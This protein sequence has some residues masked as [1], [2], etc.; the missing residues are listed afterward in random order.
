MTEHTA[1]WPEGVVARYVTVA[2]ALVDIWY[3]NGTLRTRCSGETCSW[4]V[5]K[6][7]RVFYTDSAEE[8]D[9]KIAAAVPALQPDAQ[10][11][12]EKCR[13]LPRPTT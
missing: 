3:D 10:A 13:A 9:E 4:T 8:R 7:T 2:E 5:R 1:A 12:A 6:S 11:H